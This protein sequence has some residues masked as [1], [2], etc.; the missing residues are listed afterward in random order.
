MITELEDVCET[1]PSSKFNVTIIYEAVRDGIRAKWFSDQLAAK[2]AGECELNLNI[3]NFRVLRIHEVRNI[4][5]SLAAAADVVIF[6]MSGEREFP[7][8]VQEWIEMWS[9][10]IDLSHPM[11]IA[12]FAIPAAGFVSVRNRLQSVA[13][14]KGLNFLAAT[15]QEQWVLTLK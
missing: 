2:A 9:W 4:A 5:A 14:R 10:L 7:P 1:I 6:S 12:I 11:V 3:W 13:I 8:T 15:P